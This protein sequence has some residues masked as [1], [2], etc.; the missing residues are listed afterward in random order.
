GGGAS[1]RGADGV[2]L[3]AAELA[4]RIEAAEQEGGEEGGRGGQGG[5]QARSN[6][7]GLLF[8]PRAGLPPGSARRAEP[9]GL[10]RAGD[11]RSCER[12]RRSASTAASRSSGPALGRR[13]RVRLR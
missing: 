2:D 1:G 9:E 8:G 12:G 13:L 4:G 3:T 6:H 7:G 10:E 5:A 11:H